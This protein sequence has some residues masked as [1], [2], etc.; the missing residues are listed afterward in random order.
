MDQPMT[1]S[2][3]PARFH[4]FAGTLVIRALAPAVFLLGFLAQTVTSFAADLSGSYAARGRNSNGSAYAGTVTLVQQG[5]QVAISWRI[6][7]D[8]FK[9]TGRLEGKVLEVE[10][11]NPQPVIYVLRPDGSL[12][13]TWGNG[14]ALEKLTP[15]R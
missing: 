13:G 11:G 9:G 14:E 12:H 15:V 8:T 4:P 2:T 3:M 6:G 7:N 1:V 10:W 5:D